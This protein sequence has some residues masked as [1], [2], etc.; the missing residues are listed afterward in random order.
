MPEGRPVAPGSDA[1]GG[2]L[3][4]PVVSGGTGSADPWRLASPPGTGRPGRSGGLAA[5]AAHRR[6]NGGRM[7]CAEHRLPPGYGVGS[8]PAGPEAEGPAAYLGGPRRRGGTTADGAEAPGRRD[9]RDRH[10]RPQRRPGG[11]VRPGA[12]S[13][14]GPGDAADRSALTG[15]PVRLR[16]LPFHR[17]PG[18]ASRWRCR[19]RADAAVRKES[20][21]AARLRETGQKLRLP[22]PVLPDLG[23]GGSA[24]PGGVPAIQPQRRRR[25]GFWRPAAGADR[26]LRVG[27]H[28]GPGGL[29]GPAPGQKLSEPAGLWAPRGG[30]GHRQRSRCL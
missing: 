29:H 6:G 10:L 8:L 22:G 12:E 16:P 14:T 4:S 25:V 28:E 9:R 15:G 7:L 26:G 27:R 3:S 2:P 11:P 18:R 23:P 19:G 20:G 17:F 24:C 21:H 5:P 13:D 30:P 1:C